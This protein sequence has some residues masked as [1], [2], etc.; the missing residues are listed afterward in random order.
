MEKLEKILFTL[1]VVALISL[2][3]FMVISA[4]EDERREIK[5]RDYLCRE[6]Y[7]KDTMAYDM[8]CLPFWEFIFKERY[9][10]KE[11]KNDGD[12]N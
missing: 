7:E 3:A 1:C 11:K 5:R 10:G 12:G 9:Q 4:R 2:C 6:V 8:N